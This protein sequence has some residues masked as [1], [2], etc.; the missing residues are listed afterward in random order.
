MD[1]N[2]LKDY[3][4]RIKDH[5]E[6]SILGVVL[7]FWDDRGATNNA[8]VNAIDQAFP[9]LLFDTKIRRDIAVSRSVLKGLPTTIAYPY[10][11]AAYDFERLTCELNKRVKETNKCLK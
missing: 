2:R 3:H 4:E 11:R 9:N 7:S 6:L 10:S 5:H 8:F 1:I